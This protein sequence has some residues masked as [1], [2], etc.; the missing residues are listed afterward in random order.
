MAHAEE[1]SLLQCTRPRQSELKPRLHF[2]L[3]NNLCGLRVLCV[4]P[5]RASGAARVAERTVMPHAK[6][7]KGT[8]RLSRN[9]IQTSVCLC[10]TIR[11]SFVFPIRFSGPHTATMFPLVNNLCG[12]RVLCVRPLRAGWNVK[13]S[14]TH[15][16]ASR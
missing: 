11:R 8:A 7:T 6:A 4:R 16:Y 12:L 5:L 15:S 9:Q 10:T 3:G 1:E 13:A 2:P 14:R